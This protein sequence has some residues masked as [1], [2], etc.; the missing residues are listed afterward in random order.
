M[1]DSVSARGAN[2]PSERLNSEREFTEQAQAARNSVIE[3]AL[4]TCA[5]RSERSRYVWRAGAGGDRLGDGVC[6]EQ[7]KWAI[8]VEVRASSLLGAQGQFV[9][10]IEPAAFITKALR[11]GAVP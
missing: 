2:R 1:I 8:V 5:E 6:D 11:I 10:A 4:A 9:P 7:A 3:G